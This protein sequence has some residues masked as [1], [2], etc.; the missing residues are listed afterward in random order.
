MRRSGSLVRLMQGILAGVLCIVALTPSVVLAD[1]NFATEM[2]PDKITL[3][4]KYPTV[5]G[6]ADTRFMFAVDLKYELTDL[7]PMMGDYDT[8]RLQ[9]RVFDLLL[10]GP[11][12]WEVF[13]AESSWQLTTRIAAV[14]LSALGLPQSLVVVAYAPYW[15]NPE[16]GDYPIK[17]EV[18]S[19]ELYDA[20]D[21]TARITAWYGLDVKTASDRL[22]VKT[23]AGDPVT[24]DLLV[25]NTGRATLDTVTLSSTKPDGIANENWAVKYDPAK[26]EDLQPG[27][28]QDVSVIITPPS[29]TIAGEYTVTL[30]IAGKPSLSQEPPSL[31]IRV[32]V[33]TTARW[34][35]VGLA[36]V[37]GTVG[38]LIYAFTAVRQ[39]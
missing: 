33:A 21:L 5:T 9:R 12:G 27:E 38:A 10:T 16:P 17:V 22:N 11:E 23:T 6:P 30:D 15:E 8:G 18:R 26:I 31:D 1:S 25:S 14:N 13:V 34:L 35:I 2:R 32:S 20:I 4:S 7:D 24:L 19:G 29:K 37:L 28:S 39:R 3:T 36:I